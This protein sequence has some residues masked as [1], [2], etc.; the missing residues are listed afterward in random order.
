MHAPPHLQVHHAPRSSLA[1]PSSA[2][3]F[4]LQSPPA[5]TCPTRLSLFPLSPPCTSRLFA[6]RAPCGHADNRSRSRITDAAAQPLLCAHML[7]V[8]RQALPQPESLRL[9]ELNCPPPSAGP[10]ANAPHIVLHMRAPTSCTGD[11]GRE[12]TGP[13]RV[14]VTSCAP[15]PRSRHLLLATRRRHPSS[16]HP[17]DRIVARHRSNIASAFPASSIRLDIELPA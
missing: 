6:G 12:R 5:R 11:V 13:R 7:P 10:R 17:Y 3:T 2:R 4:P 8:K 16:G 9:Q 1:R 14:L 15:C